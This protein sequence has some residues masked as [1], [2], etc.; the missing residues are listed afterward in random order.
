MTKHEW[1]LFCKRTNDPKLAFIEYLLDMS[2]IPNRRNGHS[3]HAP[4]LEVPKN[5]LA[6]ACYILDP[7]DDM[8][9]DDEEFVNGIALRDEGRAAFDESTE[10]RRAGLDYRGRS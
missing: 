1:H 3:F 7:I 4:I 10:L 2:G 8:D 9:D 6:H 5:R